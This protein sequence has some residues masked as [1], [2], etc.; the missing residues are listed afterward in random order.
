MDTKCSMSF[1]QP[2]LP[3]D[4]LADKTVHRALIDAILERTPTG[5]G[6]PDES[7]EVA[8]KIDGQGTSAVMCE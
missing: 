4:Q 6:L 3:A 7:L 2:D 1:L 8:F 5:L